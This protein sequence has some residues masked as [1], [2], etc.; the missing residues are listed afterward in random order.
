MQAGD[1]ESGS[2]ARRLTRFTV[3][4]R[5]YL[6]M[7]GLFVGAA[8]LVAAPILLYFA[9]HPEQFFMRSDQ[10]LIFSPDRSQGDPLGAFFGNIRRH[11]LA[12]GSI[13]DW[14]ERHNAP[15]RPMLTAW[16]MVLFTLGAGTAL[17]RWR[18]PAQ[19]LLLL[20]LVVL[21]IPAALAIEAVDSASFLR[22]IGIAPAVYLLIGAGLWEA[23]RLFGALAR[24]LPGRAALPYGKQA[25]SAAIALGVAICSVVAAQGANTYRIYFG[26]LAAGSRYFKAFHGEWTGVART[27]G[28][29]PSE[30]GSVFLLPY[31]PH[32]NFGFRYLYQGATPALF[33]DAGALDLPL[34]IE[35]K[36]KE[37]E[38]VTTVKVLDWEDSL[39]WL[40][41]NTHVFGIIGKY[42]RHQGSSAYRN[43]TIHSYTDVS[44]NGPWTLYDYLEPRDVRF[45]GGI[46]LRGVALGQGSKQLPSQEV[47]TLEGNRSLWV[48]LQWLTHPDLVVDYAVSLRLHSPRGRKRLPEGPEAYSGRPGLSAHQRLAGGRGDRYAGAF[49][50][51]VHSAGRRVRA[52]ADRVRRRNAGT[53]GR[54]RCV[55][56]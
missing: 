35:S 15:G 19:R 28:A 31:K 18:R 13:G 46:E 11:L 22:M 29:M 53:D 2:S 54:D 48:A 24:A 20:W 21:F 1:G 42:G 55:G 27:L 26:E 38:G 34:V 44:L 9:L 43:F 33:V 30:T 32:E 10:V 41:R 8:G 7:I 49:S 39:E 47:F 45:D 56:A 4:V 37:V 16:E 6:P 17:W 14:S 36:L 25:K 3:A 50:H 12:F 51:P 5:P 40:A 23:Y 52:E